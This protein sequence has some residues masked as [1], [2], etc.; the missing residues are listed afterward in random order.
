MAGYLTPTEA[1]RLLA[2]DP[3]TLGRA[4]V[5]NSISPTPAGEERR[6]GVPRLRPAANG[7]AVSACVGFP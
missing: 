2:A 4:E 3:A 5:L 7:F 6:V 1:G